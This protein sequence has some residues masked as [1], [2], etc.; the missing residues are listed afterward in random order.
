MHLHLAVFQIGMLR[1]I[2][3]ERRDLALPH[4]ARP[5][6][7]H[8]EQRVDDVRFAGSIGSHNGGER[9]MERSDFLTA[10]V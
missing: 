3:D 8:K 10:S 1:A 9:R 6:T 5:E 2:V 7:E 4:L